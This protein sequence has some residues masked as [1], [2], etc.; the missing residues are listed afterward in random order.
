MS[1]K[2]VLVL[3]A[4]FAL[5]VGVATASARDA[6]SANLALSPDVVRCPGDPASLCFGTLNGNGLA[7]TRDPASPSLVTIQGFRS[8]GTPGFTINRPV[9]GNGRIHFVGNLGCGEDNYSQFV[10]FSA[11]GTAADGTTITTN[12]IATAPC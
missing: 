2:V 11:S 1:R 5:A 9:D 8:D 10:N 6:N 7:P 4:A 3:C 12:V